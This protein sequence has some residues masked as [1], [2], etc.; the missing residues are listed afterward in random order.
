MLDVSTVCYLSI[1]LRTEVDAT[2]HLQLSEKLL[3]YRKIKT[4][5]GT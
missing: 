4:K 3:I 2:V 1:N 5:V